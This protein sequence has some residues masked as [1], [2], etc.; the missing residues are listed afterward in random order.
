M[1][2]VSFTIKNF[3]KFRD[4]NNTIQFVKPRAIEASPTE[5]DEE[6]S[7]ISQSSTLIIGKN[8]VGKTTIARAFEFVIERRK[9]ARS[10]D[11]NNECL[12]SY[13]N[14]AIIAI[15]SGKGLADL[16]LPSMGFELEIWLNLKTSEADKTSLLSD[17]LSLSE[18]LGDVDEA[19]VDIKIQVSIKEE[20]VF[21]QKIEQI[22]NS[23]PKLVNGEFNRPALF[24]MMCD[25]INKDVEFR[26]TN[27]NANNEEVSNLPLRS[28][29]K[30][31]EIKANRHLND[32]VLSKLYGKVVKS[33]FTNGS[34]KNSLNAHIVGINQTITQAV[35]NKGQSISGVLQEIEQSNHVTVDLTGNVTEEAILEELIKYSFSE[36]GDFIPENQFGLGYINLLN[37]I[38][39]IVGFVDSYEDKSHQ[40]QINLL[41]IEE[42][43]SFMHPQMQEFFISRIDAALKKALQ[44]SS[45]KINC[46]LIITTHS[47]HI[48]NSKIH[49]SNSFNN[50]NYICNSN[51]SS[52]V[53]SLEDSKIIPGKTD[54]DIKNL[55]FLKKHI[56]FKV[57]EL[58]FSDAV[59]FVEGATEEALLYFY[60]EKNP[61]LR[62]FYISIFNIN[63]AHGKVYYP[64]AK[65]LKVPTLVITD[66]DIQ[67]DDA[68]KDDYK[69]I[70]Q[71]VGRHTTNQ[72][73]IELN[74]N[75]S[76]L[77]GINYFQDE[78]LYFVFQKDNVKGQQPTSLE[79]AIVLENYNNDILNEVLKK[80]KK[81]IYAEIVGGAEDKNN[82]ISNSYKLQKK[83][84]ENN[85]K[86]AFANAL[87]FSCI[88]SASPASIPQLPKYIRDGFTWL[89]Q[90]LV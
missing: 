46:Q 89:E 11:F 23:T 54:E 59:I 43:E 24:Q 9:E 26:F 17:F 10:S 41:F 63:G 16:A 77:D 61:I 76:L 51:K 79:E 81:N 20:V 82:L 5:S 38:G 42:P 13:L 83:I 78:S 58:F 27:F 44:S 31:K 34:S 87:L 35:I 90:S 55:N 68:E 25:F 80:V 74:Q 69:Q 88:T 84:A 4:K 62:N 22:I 32:Q 28:L 3:R 49:S 57:S 14:E 50:I 37:I 15:A 73:L 53:I 36:G 29:F 56:K 8:N 1:Y 67:R 21:K 12:K 2:L 47:S 64:L 85:D 66:I 65:L 71:L 33:E 19:I 86:S 45:K 48:V 75:S 30:V 6:Q 52:H 70:T 39:E 72:T 7:P 18:L 40:N 60:L